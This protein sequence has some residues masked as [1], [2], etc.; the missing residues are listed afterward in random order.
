MAKAT[1]N[2]KSDLAA[3]LSNV[4]KTQGA[5]RNKA[6]VSY[7]VLRKLQDDGYLVRAKADAKGDRGKFPKLFVVSGKGK[8]LIGAFKALDAQ[9]AKRAAAAA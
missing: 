6:D 1:F 7:H 4:A 3:F 5:Q 9:K 8:Q 2:T